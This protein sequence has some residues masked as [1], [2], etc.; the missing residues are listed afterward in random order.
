MNIAREAATAFYGRIDM[1][2]D[3]EITIVSG[4]PRSGTSLMMQMLQRGGMTVL[5]DEIRAADIDNPRGYFELEKV[6]KI[7]EDV[8][9]LPAARGKVFKMVTQ[10]L[11]HLPATESYRIIF[12]NRDMNEMLLSQEKMLRRFGKNAIPREKMK[13]SYSLHLER[14]KTW[15]RQQTHC[16]VLHVNYSDLLNDTERE[17]ERLNQFL[18]YML[19]E[20][21]MIGAVEPSLYRNRKNLGGLGRS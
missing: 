8:S 16:V 4:L 13:R 17:A 21:S 3:S 7:K 2:L 6:K 11:Y 18:D 15:L 9:W 19:D 14:L 1:P 20:V 10:L 5:T 12:M